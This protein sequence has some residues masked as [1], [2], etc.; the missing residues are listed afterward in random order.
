MIFTISSIL[1][2]ALKHDPSPPPRAQPIRLRILVIPERGRATVDQLIR[3]AA[4]QRRVQRIY[5]LSVCILWRDG[6]DEIGNVVMIM[7]SLHRLADQYIISV[8]D[9]YE[10]LGLDR[11]SPKLVQ[12]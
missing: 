1:S 5:E 8:T 3:N 11:L 12:L 9:E 4:F 2:A 7:K 10:I 6:P